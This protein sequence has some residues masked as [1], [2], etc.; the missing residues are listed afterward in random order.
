[1]DTPLTIPPIDAE[2]PPGGLRSGWMRSYVHVLRYAAS[3]YPHFDRVSTVPIGDP[4]DPTGY[5]DLHG[6]GACGLAVADL[7]QD[8]TPEI[9]VTTLNGEFVVLRQSGGVFPAPDG[10]AQQPM[11]QTIVDGQLGAFNSIVVGDFDHVSRLDTKPEVYIA[12]T[13]GIRKFYVQ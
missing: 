5:G 2:P 3:P 10:G 8:G 13:T 7:D 6:Y 11:F 1:M 12:S 4:Y 9:L